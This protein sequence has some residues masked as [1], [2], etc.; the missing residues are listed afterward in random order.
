[1]ALDWTQLNKTRRINRESSTRLE[2]TGSMKMWETKK[3]MEKIC[4]R[5]NK[6]KRKDL[7]RGE[8]VAK[9]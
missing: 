4:R 1:M 7:E 5:G 2:S 9:R 3:N 6:R 8:E